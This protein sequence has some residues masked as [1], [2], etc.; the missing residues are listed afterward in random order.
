M[1]HERPNESFHWKN[2]L[3]ELDHLSSEPVVDKTASWER[4]HARLS[5]KKKK[6][7]IFWYQTAA[8]CVLMA[9]GISWFFTNEKTGKQVTD[10]NLYPAQRSV[11]KRSIAKNENA[12]V[13][14]QSITIIKREGE[15]AA[16]LFNNKKNA[17]SKVS[18]VVE[19][20]DVPNLFPVKDSLQEVI[21][22]T[23]KSADTIHANL[24][25]ATSSRK[26][27]RVVHINHL[28]RSSEQEIQYGRTALPSAQIKNFR[29]E[30]ISA[31]SLSKN[32]SDNIVK[33][34]LSP[35]N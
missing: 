8:A 29:N 6:N 12:K 15:K 11:N 20:N 27:L 26:K 22:N 13:D 25:T 4:L 28:E 18:T 21:I 5:Q 23:V 32:A 7:K 2:K 24:I 30:D 14:T 3:D 33:I 19:K 35:S 1:L 16:V 34:K 31:F 17:V 9:V 10:K